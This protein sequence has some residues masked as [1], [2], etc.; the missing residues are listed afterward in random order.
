MSWVALM[1]HDVDP[2]PP[3]PAGG[4]ARFTV[5]AASFEVMLDAI[6][7]EGLKGCS[8]AEAR[9]ETDGSRVAITFDD[10]TRGQLEYAVPALLRRGM[11]ATF[12]V[13][14]DWVGCPGYM[15]WTELRRIRDQGMSVQSHT[16]SHPHLSEL[17]EEALRSE[18]EESRRTIDEALQQRTTELALPGGNAPR[19]RLRRLLEACGYVAVANSRWGSNSD[20]ASGLRWVRRCNVPRDLDAVLARRILRAD[21]QLAVRHYSREAVLN[22]VRSLVGADR[23]ARWRRQVLDTLSP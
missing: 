15:T 7:V 5:S 18:L 6:D 10:G 14:T 17:G 3:A 12:F 16:K 8:L 22:G 1:Y 4:P 2:A 21:P 20:Q 23:Y 11:T 9:A 19:R 13:V